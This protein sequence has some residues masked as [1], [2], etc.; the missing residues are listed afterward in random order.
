M[1]AKRIEKEIE[2]TLLAC[3]NIDAILAN[4]LPEITSEK[5][6]ILI[7]QAA[8]GCQKMRVSALAVAQGLPPISTGS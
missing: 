1:N 5:M 2:K 3:D 4:R 7:I 6:A 8:L